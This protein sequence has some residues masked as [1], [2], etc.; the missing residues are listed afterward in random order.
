M[1]V[2]NSKPI[3]YFATVK[4]TKDPLK[5]GRVQVELKSLDKP[6]EMPWLRVI[7]GQASK[8]SG[9]FL[10]PEKGDTVAILRGHQENV[11]G[12]LILGG[13]YDKVNAPPIFDKDGKNS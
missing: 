10:L 11:H 6:V 1:S 9:T 12:M 3:I 7:Q 8:Q 2:G 13:V 4:D 5:L